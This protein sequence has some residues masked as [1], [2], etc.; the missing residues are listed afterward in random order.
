M[1]GFFL[2]ESAYKYPVFHA[3]LRVCLGKD[4]AL[5]S[6]KIVAL[7]L[8]RQFHVRLADP[9]WTPQ[10]VPGLTATLKGGMP[11]IVTQ[12]LV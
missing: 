6:M 11:V 8:V 3:G 12:R 9:N 4:M 10:F 2:P 5:L 7:M 1:K